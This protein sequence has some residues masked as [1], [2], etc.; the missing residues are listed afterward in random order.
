MT[1]GLGATRGSHENPS[2]GVSPRSGALLPSPGPESSHDCVTVP[3]RAGFL[4]RSASVARQGGVA[5]HVTPLMQRLRI[6]LRDEWLLAILVAVFP[7]LVWLASRETWLGFAGLDRLVHWDTIGALAGLMVLSRG[8]EDSGYL[9][10][11]GRWLLARV[12]SER[13]LALMLVLFAAA[14]SA[15]VTNDVTLFIVVPLTL[16]L[17]SVASLPVGRLVVFEALAVNAGSTLSPVGN[18]QN[19]Y[20]W[21]I[22]DVPFLEFC[23]AMAPL[24]AALTA[25]LVVLIPFAFAGGRIEVA[26]RLADPPPRRAL[27][28]LSLALYPAFLVCAELDLAVAAASA[29]VVLYAA[30]ARAV[31]REVDWILLAVFVL[32]FV[33]LGLLAGIPA[34]AAGAADLVQL[35]GGMLTAGVVAS[36]LISNVPAAI[37]LAG[38]S[39]DW[40][41]LAWGVSVG[42]FGFAIGSMA[43]LIAL[44]LAR[45]PGLWRVFHAW[46][47]PVL[48][49][50]WLIAGLTLAAGSAALP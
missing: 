37:F 2:Y 43:N 13:T 25:L 22:A 42:G 23:L 18:P 40:R 6:F 17:S 12:H 32:M 29:I 45:Q 9:F 30:V 41:A 1:V 24:A 7:P 21:Q 16:G 28:W 11:A 38:F 31:L 27:L 36:Q 39:D 35:P 47:I 33:D 20:L 50:G 8:L 4:Y 44:R 3:P 46:S 10:R 19:L 5:P 14:L 48:A 34:V 15:V 49:A 26:E